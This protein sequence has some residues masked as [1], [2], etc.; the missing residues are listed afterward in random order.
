LPKA[1]SSGVSRSDR[2]G[3]RQATRR[4][5]EASA[6]AHSRGIRRVHQIRKREVAKV[7][8]AANIRNA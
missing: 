6:R 5:P 3:W 2:R 4:S 8:K 1:S 7:M